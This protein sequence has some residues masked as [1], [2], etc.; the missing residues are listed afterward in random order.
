MFS[1]CCKEFR[2][3]PCVALLTTHAPEHVQ[4]LASPL[5]V[6]I[7]RIYGSESLVRRIVCVDSVSVFRY[8]FSI[9]RESVLPSSSETVCRLDESE[10]KLSSSSSLLHLGTFASTRSPH[11]PSQGEVK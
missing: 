2:V 4:L 6:Y 9:G 8:I 10:M 7:H 11:Q 3:C 5:R 1:S